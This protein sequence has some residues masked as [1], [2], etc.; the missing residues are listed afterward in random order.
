MIEVEQKYRVDDLSALGDQIQAQFSVVRDSRC[1]E[2]DQYLDFPAHLPGEGE[3]LRVRKTEFEDGPG[4]QVCVT[5]K[6]PRLDAAGESASFKARQEIEVPLAGSDG[7]FDRMTELFLALGFRR[8]P[9]VNK[10]RRRMAFDMDGRRVE[11]ALDEVAGLGCFAELETMADERELDA[12]R[13]TILQLARQLGLGGAITASYRQLMLAAT[14][15]P[16]Q[17]I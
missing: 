13:R 10:R 5:W 9:V 16:N 8:G 4:V 17:G 6:G 14:A 2:Q 15:S 7:Q 3:A 11:I 1:R 12:A